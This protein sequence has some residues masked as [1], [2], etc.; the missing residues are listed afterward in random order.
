MT[1]SERGNNVRKICPA[2]LP[3]VVLFCAF[4]MASCQKKDQPSGSRSEQAAN[5]YSTDTIFDEVYKKVQQ[6]PADAEA[7]YHLADLYDRNAQYP[8]AIETYK[9]VVSLKPDMGYAYFK[10]G[11]A[12][13]RLNQPAEALKAFRAAAKYL[14]KHAVLYNNM[15][16]AYGKLGRL[17]DE[18]TAL[19]TA[20]KLRPSYSAARYNLGVT[21]IKTKNIPA[22]RKEYESLK[23]L[24]EGAAESLL[25]EIEK[26]S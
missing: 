4:M 26:V 16:I 12:Y 9:K 11:T 13:D 15:G 2:V 17:N 7:M 8:E 23:R 10:M 14:P 1:R 19:K 3:L 25:K 22:A 18:I 6:N 5:P 24:D 20:I 21:Y